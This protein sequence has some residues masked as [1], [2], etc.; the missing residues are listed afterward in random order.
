MP[1]SPALIFV[2]ECSKFGK[3]TTFCE[4]TLSKIA[5]RS[6][7]KYYRQVSST[8]YLLECESGKIEIGSKTI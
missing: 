7:T 6:Q 2:D 3:H 1:V 8:L 5:N 4:I